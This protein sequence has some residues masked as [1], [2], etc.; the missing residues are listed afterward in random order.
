LALFNARDF[1]GAHDAWESLWLERFGDEKDFLHGL[2]LCAVALHH[3][4]RRNWNGARSRFR[5][6]RER[7]E[8]YPST[9]GGVDLR[10]FLRRMTGSMHR[11]LTEKD[12]PDLDL[13]K[14]PVLKLKS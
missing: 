3:A 9:Y 2:I 7:L 8:R 6:G 5:L 12:P 10:N 14:L 11:I 4:T 13:R 1:Y